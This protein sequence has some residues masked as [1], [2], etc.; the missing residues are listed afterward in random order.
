MSEAISVILKWPLRLSPGSIPGI[1]RRKANT[2]A[3]LQA[4][5]LCADRGVPDQTFA[6]ASS[7]LTAS[8]L[9][10]GATAPKPVVDSAAAALA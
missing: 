8:G 6:A 9:G 10:R 2:G 3:I 4:L 7:F 5:A 1:N